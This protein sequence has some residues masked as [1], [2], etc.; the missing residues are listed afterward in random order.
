VQIAELF[1]GL[2]AVLLIAIMMIGSQ[3]MKAARSNPAEVLKSE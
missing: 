1:V 2:L 3:T